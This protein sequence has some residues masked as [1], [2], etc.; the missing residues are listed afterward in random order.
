[1]QYTNIQIT[2]LQYNIQYTIYNIRYTI[3]TIIQYKVQSPSHPSSIIHHTTYNVASRVSCVFQAEIQE[4]KGKQKGQKGGKAKAKGKRTDEAKEV[5]SA[6]VGT[7]VADLPSGSEDPSVV[8]V[9]SDI[10]WEPDTKREEEEEEVIDLDAREAAQAAD[11]AFQQSFVSAV[12]LPSDPEWDAWDARRPRHK[13]KGAVSKAQFKKPTL[14]PADIERIEE[15]IKKQIQEDEKVL[16]QEVKEEEAAG[17]A[18]VAAGSTSLPGPRTAAMRN[19]NLFLKTVENGA[20]EAEKLDCTALQIAT[21][22]LQNMRNLAATGRLDVEAIFSPNHF[23]CFCTCIHGREESWKLAAPLQLAAAMK[24]LH[25][26]KFFVVTFADDE[27]VQDWAAKHFQWAIAAG[28]LHMASGG[29]VGL[30]QKK[31]SVDAQLQI[32]EGE[33]TAVPIARYWHASLCKNSSHIFALKHMQKAG[34]PTTDFLLCNLDADNIFSSNY[35]AAVARHWNMEKKL[36]VNA[37]AEAG[38]PGSAGSIPLRALIATSQHDGLTG[39]ICLQASDFTRLGGYDQETG[40]VGSGYQ[41]V[42]LLRRLK[43][44]IKLYCKMHPS[45]YPLRASA[46]TNQMTEAAGACFPNQPGASRAA[47]RGI[48]KIQNC[49]PDDIK[50]FNR[51]WGKFNTVNHT[52]MHAKMSQGRLGRNGMPDKPAFTEQPAELLRQFLSM[53]LGSWFTPVSMLA[54]PQPPGQ[55]QEP[56]SSSSRDVP[57]EPARARTKTPPPEPAAPGPSTAEAERRQ[58]TK[59]RDSLT[60]DV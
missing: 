28:F 39:R 25:N 33:T 16:K 42:D 34:I 56:A 4:E 19:F 43:E 7:E 30:S 59:P 60:F 47:D 52:N 54:A 23:L 31:T 17:S 29:V 36:L 45:V 12:T 35:I 44:T 38:D 50:R 57:S 21:N 20:R 58:Q 53:S 40:I 24:Y 13:P 27:A 32:R 5:G 51:S 37:A 55:K 8:S 2:N 14:E 49:N 11:R 18:A 1:M 15:R 26:V 10:D 41:D 6:T 22:V 48:L 9:H 46:L 3:Y